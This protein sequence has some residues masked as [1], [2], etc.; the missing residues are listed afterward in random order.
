M[1][2]LLAWEPDESHPRLR[3]EGLVAGG[4]GGGLD[5]KIVKGEDVGKWVNALTVEQ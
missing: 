1:S 3:T 4:F 2:E 5:V